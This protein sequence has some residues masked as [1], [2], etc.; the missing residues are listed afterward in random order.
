MGM[1]MGT[2]GLWEAGRALSKE[3]RGY[4]L[5]ILNVAR[6]S[7]SAGG[8]GDGS[9][10]QGSLRVASGSWGMETHGL[11]EWQALSGDGRG[12]GLAGLQAR[13][14]ALRASGA[15]LNHLPAGVP[16]P[17]AEAGG[18]VRLG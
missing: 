10:G 9:G 18:I 12:P 4:V 14:G 6:R 17:Q 5:A 13:W 1:D 7:G 16:P 15:R 3:G 8:G 2:R 11:G